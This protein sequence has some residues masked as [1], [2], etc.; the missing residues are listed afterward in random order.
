MGAPPS[1]G[2]F[3]GGGPGGGPMGMQMQPQQQSANADFPIPTGEF[4]PHKWSTDHSSKGTIVCWANDD[5][6]T[7]GH[8][9]R[10]R[11]TY[12]I[13][14]P[15]FGSA[16]VAK[17][18]ADAQTFAVA[19]KPSDWS[20]N[21][22]VPSTVNFWVVRSP[23]HDTVPIQVFSWHEGESKGKIF[24]VTAGDAIGNKE[25]NI[26]YSTGW[27]LVD[28]GD[29]SRNGE[30]ILLMDPTGKLHKR[31]V[32]TDMQDPKFQS[33]KKDAASAAAAAANP[34]QSAA[35]ER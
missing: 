1:S 25:S 23:N 15:L 7:P 11:I 33:M 22:N 10:Y 19:S 24:E 18:A 17:N 26:D 30:F 9:Y 2:G 29:D 20:A 14:N 27:T 8:T 35:A 32:R 13:K 6:I 5:T 4:D 3:V 21:V 12:K 31:D 34:N 28:V 16:N